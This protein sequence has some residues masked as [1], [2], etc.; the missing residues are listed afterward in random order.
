MLDHPPNNNPFAACHAGR[1]DPCLDRPFR[2]PLL[3]RRWKLKIIRNATPQFDRSRYGR[4]G[5]IRRIGAHHV[6]FKIYEPVV[7]RIHQV[8]TRPLLLFQKVGQ[9]IA[10]QVLFRVKDSVTGGVRLAR[11]RA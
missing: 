5:W 8:R 6:F 9:A 4:I 7:V 10:V 2:K 1:L 11:I 3:Q